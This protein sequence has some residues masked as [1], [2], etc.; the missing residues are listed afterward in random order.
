M[1]GEAEGEAQQK[2]D[3]IVAKAK[4]SIEMEKRA[5][6]ADIKNQVATLSIEIAEKVIGKELST[7]ERQHQMIDKMLQ[8]ATLN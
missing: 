4:E 1:I 6:M 5:A 3:V 2:A 7:E 8:E